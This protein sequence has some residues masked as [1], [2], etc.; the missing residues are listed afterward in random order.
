MRRYLIIVSLIMASLS[1]A[2]QTFS[3]AREWRGAIVGHTDKKDYFLRAEIKAVAGQK[4]LFRGEFFLINSNYSGEF[5]SDMKLAGNKLYLLNFQPRKEYP[6]PNPSLPKCFSGYFELSQ[7][8]KDSVRILDLYRN[9][10][11][12]S[13]AKDYLSDSATG[14][15]RPAFDCFSF[16][17][18]SN[19]QKDTALLNLEKKTD[20]ILA[21]KKVKTDIS[22]KRVTV[23]GKQFQ[24]MQDT[25]EIQVWDNNMIDGD[26]ISLKLN[27]DWIVTNQPLVREKL[28]LK[29]PLSGKINDL[30]LLAENLG[31]TPPN[32]AAIT[33]SDKAGTKTFYLQSDF[34]KSE[35]LKIIKLSP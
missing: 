12:F 23:T 6:K 5:V 28:I 7:I 22:S 31:K 2:A 4:D 13:T 18:L 25:I 27:D 1:L 15:M 10:V 16:V 35:V 26:S 3:P 30:L 29:L 21:I 17:V 14:E 32:T 33:L 20:S 9:P 19:N 11:P 24:T 8:G 34:K